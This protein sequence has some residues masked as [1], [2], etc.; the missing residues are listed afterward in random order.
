MKIKLLHISVLLNL[1]TL[2]AYAV[3]AEPETPPLT[4]ARV[5]EISSTSAPDVRLADMAIAEGEARLAGAGVR[6]LE[7]PK[8][9]LSAGPR[10]GN[11]TSLDAELGLEI[12]FELG[13]RRDKRI[14][15]AQAG[16]R[17]EQQS[18]EEVRRQAISAA[19]ASFYRVLQAEERLK[20]A[21]ERKSVADQLL[22]VAKE[23]HAA[24]DVATFE[25]NLA[26][27]EV[28]RADSEVFS[29]KGRLASARSALAGSLGLP[30]ARGIRTAGSIKDRSFFDAIAS[31]PHPQ[32]R[33]DLQAAL[34]D[35]EVSR[36][37][38]ALAEAERKPDLS[39]RVS[40]KREGDE[41]VALGGITVGL[42]FFNPR[43]AQVQEARV[44]HRRAQLAAEIRESALSAELEGARDAYAAALEAVRRMES[45]GLALQKEN[46]KLAH[47]SYRAGK[48]N[49]ATLLQLRRDA[50]ETGREYLERLLEAAEAGVELASASGAWTTTK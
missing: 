4:L 11:G 26:R 6:A 47:E 25:V 49:L 2:P 35:V 33:A 40:L 20:L 36:A 45:D 10:S 38:I 28:A 39:F 16:I 19:V 41:N 21:Q 1:C 15:L 48:I 43:Q 7:N 12:P 46:E 42:P 18:V 29:A 30:T 24:G 17:R 22:R 13:Q 23:R 50:L 32:S 37:R 31:A 3:A 14:A 34:A 27:T 5:I 9:D 44:Q 8:L